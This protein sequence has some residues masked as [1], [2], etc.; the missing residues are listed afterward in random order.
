MLLCLKQPAWRPPQ[1]RKGLTAFIFSYRFR[2]D[3]T[4]PW[5]NWRLKKLFCINRSQGMKDIYFC[6]SGFCFRYLLPVPRR[7]YVGGG[8]SQ[9]ESLSQ[10]LKPVWFRAAGLL[11]RTFSLSLPNFFCLCRRWWGEILPFCHKN[12]I[13]VFTLLAIF[14]MPLPLSVTAEIALPPAHVPHSSCLSSGPR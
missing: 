1:D 7:M 5:E 10:W 9:K 13:N 8:R 3:V 6:L 14:I 4:S 11:C 12:I 2:W